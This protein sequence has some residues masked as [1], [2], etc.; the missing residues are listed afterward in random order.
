VLGDIRKSGTL[1]VLT[2][3]TSTSYYTE[4]DQP[5]GPEYELAKAF[6]DFLGVKLELVVKD[7]IAELFTA[8]DAGEAHLIAAGISRTDDRESGYRF[9]PDYQ[10]VQQQVV[11]RRDQPLPAGPAELVGRSLAVISD[12]SHLETLTRW[13]QQYPEISWQASSEQS[14]EQ[15]MS[16]VAEGQVDCVLADSNSVAVNLRYLPGLAVAFAADGAQSLAWVLP[17]DGAR[18]EVELHK[19]LDSAAA[20]TTLPAILYRYYSHVELYDEQ[21]LVV[22]RE[23]ID[24]RLPELLPLFQ[25]H[26]AKH[27]LPWTLIAALA[28]QESH[29]DP[30]AVS[31]TGVRGVMMLTRSTAE[32]MGVR[33]RTDAEQSIA[34]G[35]RYL[36]RMLKRLP[37]SIR[38]DDRHWFALAAYTLGMGHVQDARALAERRGQDPDSWHSVAEVLPLLSQQ[39]HYRTL[40]HGYARGS[41]AV[42]YVTQVRNYQDMLLHALP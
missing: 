4:H 24:G 21:D 10:T 25:R 40:P 38:S 29:W 41:D 12:S 26:A 6:A 22:M 15:I 42:R 36:A 34:G 39:R 1:R 27:K 16:R 5:S 2:R 7:S 19:W 30:R 32:V 9:G 3:N 17:G 13:Q 31:P 23:R 28:Y 35:T 11:C 14:S 18:L 20:E 37:A 33:D 8:L